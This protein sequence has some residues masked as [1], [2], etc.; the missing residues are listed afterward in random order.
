MDPEYNPE[1]WQK[2]IGGS[3][4][5]RRE[6][7][8][9]SLLLKEIWDA[10]QAGKH[11]HP[12]DDGQNWGFRDKYL[13]FIIGDEWVLCLVTGDRGRHK[14]DPLVASLFDL[15]PEEAKFAL[16]DYKLRQWLAGWFPKIQ[17]DKEE[18]QN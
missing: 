17:P 9:P 15:T 16:H 18:H 8:N 10:R 7:A 11:V 1:Y 5:Q 14:I 3:A 12:R 13:G 6:V 4:F 2:L